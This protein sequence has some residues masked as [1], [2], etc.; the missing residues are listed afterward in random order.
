MNNNTNTSAPASQQVIYVAQGKSRTAYILLALLFGGRGIHDFYAGF[1]GK[2]FLK[3][4]ISAIGSLF[5]FLGGLGAVA[6]ASLSDESA[7]ASQEVAVI[8]MVGLLMLSLQALYILIQIFT[9]TR[10]SKGIP[11]N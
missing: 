5:F 4:V 3:M 11:F 2:G 6:A 1:V 7:S 9:Q 8:P 10:D